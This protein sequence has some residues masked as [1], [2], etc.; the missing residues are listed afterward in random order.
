MF[1]TVEFHKFNKPEV[2]ETGVLVR[3][4]ENATDAEIFDIARLH[5]YRVEFERFNGNIE[6][7]NKY[8]NSIPTAV[9]VDK[10]PEPM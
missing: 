7:L 9:L 5:L 2:A 1:A 3:V 6:K 4:R 8:I 10:E